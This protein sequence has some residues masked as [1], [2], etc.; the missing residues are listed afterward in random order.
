MEELQK[1]KLTVEQE[2][3]MIEAKLREVRNSGQ[4]PDMYRSK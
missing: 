4:R 3:Q 1:K 2:K